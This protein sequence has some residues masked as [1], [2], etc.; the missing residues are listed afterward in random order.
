MSST[1][2][3]Y[4][5]QQNYFIARW[6]YI[7]ELNYETESGLYSRLEPKTRTKD[8]KKALSFEVF[9]PL[10]LLTRQWQFGRFDGN[11]CGTPVSVKIKAVKKRF[12]QVCL[13][14]ES[15]DVENRS[16]STDT[17]LEYEVEKMDAEITPY[18]RVQSA[19]H[20][21]KRLLREFDSATYSKLHE[22]LMKEFCSED[23]YKHQSINNTIETLKLKNNTALKDFS[24]AYSK[25]TFDG[26]KLYQMV[27]FNKFEVEKKLK[28]IV[29]ASASKMM[30]LLKEYVS[31]FDA[32]YFPHKRTDSCWSN[33]K[34]GYQVEIHQ[35]STKYDAE[36]YDNGRLSWYSFDNKDLNFVKRNNN[37]VKRD[38]SGFGTIPAEG[39]ILNYVSGGKNISSEISTQKDSPKDVEEKMFSYI[40]VPA[41]FTGAPSQKL[42][43]FENTKVNMVADDEKD[44]SML[45]TAAIMQYI[46]MYSN[47]WMIVPLET[48][49]GVVLDVKGVVIK[50]SFGERIYIEEDAEDV[51]GNNDSDEFTDRWNL[52][53]IASAQAFAKDNFTTARGLLF[54][55][56]VQ[57]TE[58]SSPIE[59]VQ[60]LRD[61]M[62][63]MVWGVETK[64]NDGCGGTLDGKTLSDAVFRDVDEK[65]TQ[66]EEASTK[67]NAAA[68]KTE[69]EYS[70]LVQNRVP[71]NWIPF[72][73]EQLDD[74][75]NIHFRR[76]R[77]PLFYNNEFLPV[78]PSTKLL[79]TEKDRNGGVKPFYIDE[80][81]IAGYGTKLVKTAQR[82]RWFLGKTF[83][84]IGNRTIISEYQA[85]SGLLFDELIPT[86]KP[87]TIELD[88]G[89]QESENQE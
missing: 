68:N 20:F 50:D 70:L 31:W 11:D 71:L 25:R 86:K 56:V 75:R 39:N 30:G 7:H 66:N 40:P 51:D 38:S 36:D 27:D 60:F 24:A 61:E 34:L 10:W 67:E 45:A 77:M 3:F 73:P 85:N 63:N 26:Y 43:E 83:N 32:K 22:W 52:F 2:S 84:W 19:M 72:L 55:P 89:K 44:F 14:S 35:G 88:D 78:R 4:T 13:K 64:I 65:N 16:Y 37:T 49:T 8:F 79:A 33:Q 59:E 29:P 17:P 47:D 46:S 58:E 41:N 48:E 54:P 69:A 74:F 1:K 12:N 57:K 9:D 82:T 42:W 81:Q 6:N 15:G 18:I 53:G 87:R 5:N 80:N 23:F 28:D 21:K 62:A 76:A